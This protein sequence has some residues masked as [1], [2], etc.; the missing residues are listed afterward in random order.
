MVF[1]LKHS[2]PVKQMPTPAEFGDSIVVTEKGARRL[3][4]HKMELI[5]LGA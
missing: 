5:T 2:V 3:G 1:E 4:K